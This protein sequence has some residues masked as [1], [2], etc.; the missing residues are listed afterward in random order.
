[1]KK[2]RNR[3]VFFEVPKFKRVRV[4][5]G[6]RLFGDIEI[7]G[8]IFNVFRIYEEDIKVIEMAFFS[9]FHLCKGLWEWNGWKNCTKQIS[10]SWR[11]SDMPMATMS[12]FN[13]VI[14]E[15]G[16]IWTP[17]D[18]KWNLEILLARSNEWHPKM[19]KYTPNLQELYVSHTVDWSILCS[20][21]S[22]FECLSKIKY[23]RVENSLPLDLE[24]ISTMSSLEEY[25]V[26]NFG[27]GTAGGEDHKYPATLKKVIIHN[28]E[29]FG[30]SV[31][32]WFRL[33]EDFTLWAIQDDFRFHDIL[34]F[35]NLNSLCL[36]H[37][38]QNID[39]ILFIPIDV[40]KKFKFK[41]LSLYGILIE[42]WDE[43]SF[44]NSYDT[45]IELFLDIDRMDYTPPAPTHHYKFN[46]SSPMMKF[47][48]LEKISLKGFD[49]GN[50]DEILQNSTLKSIRLGPVG[51]TS[52]HENIMSLL[53]SVFGKENARISRGSI[54]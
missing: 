18:Y 10:L 49:V 21:T 2:L 41:K 4:I 20:D 31:V 44:E 28:G 51:W 37:S 12:S 42:G 14:L 45:M 33:C 43:N 15:K 54:N 7:W 9:M 52:L 46:V 38:Q 47:K 35:E 27:W 48:K 13:D 1:M 3:E 25:N 24:L 34:R 39:E 17:T 23:L 29:T 11:H 5:D 40:M 6:A 19:L 30:E 36:H 32:L 50:V 16:F 22:K 26:Q 53:W 8:L